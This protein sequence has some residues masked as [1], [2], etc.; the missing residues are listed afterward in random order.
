MF[1]QRLFS[2]YSVVLVLVLKEPDEE[3]HLSELTG[4][5]LQRTILHL[6]PSKSIFVALQ[7]NNNLKELN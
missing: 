7:Q 6:T 2:F 5:H 4:A 1:R 3:P